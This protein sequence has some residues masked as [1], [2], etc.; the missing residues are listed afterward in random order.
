MRRTTPPSPTNHSPSPAPAPASAPDALSYAALAERYEQLR[1]TCSAAE[2]ARAHY[3]RLYEQAPVAY[4]T[5]SSDGSILEL[6]QQAG[7]LLDQDP[8]QLTGIA[9]ATLV[10]PIQRWDFLYLFG[11]MLATSLPQSGVVTLRTAIGKSLTVQLE[12]TLVASPAG[13]QQCLLALLDI[14]DARQVA[15]VLAASEQKFRRLF[16]Q[17]TDAVALMQNEQFVDCNAAVLELLGATDKSQI[18]GHYPWDLAPEEQRPGLRSATYFQE[19]VAAAL[20]SGS[21]RCEGVLCRLSGEYM[22][23]EAVLTPIKTDGELLLHVLWRDISDQKREQQR[24]LQCEEQLQL[25]LTA[26]STGLWWWDVVTNQFHC[27]AQARACFGWPAT[28]AETLPLELLLT[29]IH[30]D[31]CA[32]LQAALERATQHGNLPAHSLRT[33]WPDGTVHPAVLSG[34]LVTNE[35]Y[36]PQR[37]QGVVHTPCAQVLEQ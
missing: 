4:C 20:T 17:S 11:Q 35:F 12:S 13:E 25:V 6:N 22:W 19:S 10:E 16:E 28:E 36:Q 18:L 5:L 37:V 33:L 1:H 32:P 24:R 26:T 29:A 2:A 34:K 9:F 3:R 27:N 14:T 8:R 15:L 30:P 7:T 23:V 31:D 21:K